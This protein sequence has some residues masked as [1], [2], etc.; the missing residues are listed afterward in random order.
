MVFRFRNRHQPDLRAT[1]EANIAPPPEQPVA[2]VS[3]GGGDVIDAVESDVLLAIRNVG[4]SIAAARTEVAQMRTGLEGIREQMSALVDAA[5]AAAAASSSLAVKT[6]SLSETSGQ[7]TGAMGEA[8]SHLDR[9][10]ACGIEARALITALAQAGNEI[11]GIVDTI[12]A[13]ARQTNLLA[14]NATIEAARAGQAGR[15]FAIVASEVKALSIE[16]AKAAEDVRARV[17]RLRD[18]ALSSG[19]A[20]EAVA[21][22]IESVRPAFATVRSISETQARTV[23]DVVDEAGRASGLVAHVNGN[24]DQAS[25]ATVALDR[26]ADAMEGATV[27]AAEQADSL[28]RRFLAVIRQSEIGDRRRFDRYPVELAVR[29]SDGRRTRSI[30]L[31]AGGILV[32]VPDGPTI[33]AGSRHSL[34]IETIG[35]LNATVVATSPMGLHCAFD[36]G[37]AVHQRDETT[38]DRQSEARAPIVPRRRSVDL[39]ERL[40]Q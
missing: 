21:G 4:G 34:D 30:D 7:I 2:P 25:A 35:R 15:G 31:S 20:V 5:Q 38:H 23:T 11:A 39:R 33:T 1:A 18:G 36:T 22:A 26:T 9:A 10:S 32:V 16:T 13:V 12:S 14:L 28:G 27:R 40:E 3:T 6:G 24:A 37:F 29:L 17:T 19:A 8:S